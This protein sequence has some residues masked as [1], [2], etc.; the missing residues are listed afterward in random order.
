MLA[1]EL[2]WIV[3]TD[4]DAILPRAGGHNHSLISASPTISSRV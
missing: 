3:A 4:I 2:A 1:D